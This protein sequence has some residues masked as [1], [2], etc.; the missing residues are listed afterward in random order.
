[1]TESVLRLAI[2]G[3]SGRM[4]KSLQ[5]VIEDEFSERIK[6]VGGWARLSQASEALPLCSEVEAVLDFSAPSQVLP[7]AEACVK[8]GC[9]LVTGT[10]GLEDAQRSA[11]LEA[12]TKIPVL[13]APNFS[14][15]IQMMARLLAKAAAFWKT[16][17]DIEILEKHH[18]HKAEAPSGTALFFGETIAQAM[19]TTLE[20]S[21]EWPR[22]PYWEE[23]PRAGGKIRFSCQ[24]GGTMAGTHRVDFFLRE[25]V[26]AIEHQALDRRLFARGAV[27]T[28]L[29]IRARPP[30]L[31]KLADLL[32]G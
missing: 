9:A 11:L 26:L 31:Y 15:G 30:G 27:Q 6:I 32:D 1:M 2:S 25:E 18:R 8:A 10:T 5:A 3:I 14:F 19:K 20:E 28:A 17:A 7:L 22:L 16:E 23:T 4:G 21:A 29:W 13:H 24:R 12:S